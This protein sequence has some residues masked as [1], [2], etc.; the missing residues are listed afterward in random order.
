[1]E[2]PCAIVC[3]GDSITKGYTPYFESRLRNEYADYDLRVI[4]A[5][6]PSETTRHGLARVDEILALRP[7]VC[8]VGFGMND[9][10][11]GVDREEFGR[12]LTEIV[13][14]LQA[15]HVRVLI[16]TLNP[17]WQNGQT[18]P[19]I[20]AYNSAIFE[21]VD[22]C[23]VR[24][25]DVNRLWREKLNPLRSG[26]EDAI[27]PNARGYQ[28]FAEALM[29]MV[30]R[31]STTVVWQYNGY[32]AACNYACPYCYYPTK[33]HY[34]RHSIEQWREGFLATFGKQRVTFYLSY[35]EPSLGKAFYDVLDM[36]ASE[37][38]WDAIMTTNLSTPLDRMLETNLVR[39][40]RFNINASFHPTQN[41]KPQDF[42]AQLLKL[43]EHGI[44]APVVYVMYPEQV[45]DFASH[46]AIFDRHGFLMHVRRFRGQ[47]KNRAYPEAYTEAERQLV[48]RYM[49]STSLRMMLSNYRSVGRLSYSGLF[50]VVVNNDGD[51]GTSP[52][53]PEFGTRGNVVQ[54]TARL[55]RSPEPYP[56][57]IS[58]GAV[59][60]VATFLDLG[61]R[62]LEGNHIWSYALQGDIEVAH[63]KIRYPFADA[64]FTD[65][66]FRRKHNFGDRYS[67]MYYSLR[68]PI[69][70]AVAALSK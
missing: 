28:V 9:W 61:L 66:C 8:V 53:F 7:T 6:I 23:N 17:D 51:L 1:M 59:D 43:R 27:H 26:L 58:E 55:D 68:H 30:P 46:F 18:T 39:S 22:R 25:V 12:N 10:R 3:F 48:A 57:D 52:E 5:G 24:V 50:Y 20:D 32:Y 37:P 36:I 21:V 47:Y 16:L 41:V 49:D 44:E 42:L 19:T 63:G 56:G 13:R 40:G 34:F 33:R 4:N 70:A 14:R 31:V 54:K 65:P 67:N 38:Q 11:K 45:P 69:R 62:E 64:D 60:G 15:A 35:G 29:R 2:N